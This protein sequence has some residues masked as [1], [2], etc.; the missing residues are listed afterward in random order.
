MQGRSGGLNSSKEGRKTTSL[1]WNL[2]GL[3]EEAEMGRVRKKKS[4][5]EREETHTDKSFVLKCLQLCGV[6]SLQSSPPVHQPTIRSLTCATRLSDQG[7]GHLARLARSHRSIDWSDRR[8]LAAP[9]NALLSSPQPGFLFFLCVT[10]F[11]FD[12]FFHPLSCAGVSG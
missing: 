1:H 3:P 5:E 8:R 7:V 11:L 12:F 9:Q 4:N 6:P 2:P 10:I